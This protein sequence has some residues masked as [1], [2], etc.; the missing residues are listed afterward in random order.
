MNLVNLLFPDTQE[1]YLTQHSCG[2]RRNIHHIHHIH[3]AACHHHGPGAY[4]AGPRSFV[5]P[6]QF[7]LV[8]RRFLQIS[9]VD[10]SIST[11]LPVTETVQSLTES[12]L[13]AAF[14]PIS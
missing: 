7:E 2:T 12:Y 3:L 13:L 14:I 6:D 10:N 1:Q 9:G 4:S 5:S 11:K 8:L